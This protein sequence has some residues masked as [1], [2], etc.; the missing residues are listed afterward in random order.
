M[1]KIIIILSSALLLN[2][3]AIAVKTYLSD[4]SEGYSVDC[5][6]KFRTWDACYRQ[7]GQKC[8]TK[9]YNIID[10]IEKPMIVDNVI[11]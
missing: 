6:G 10:K 8:G 3:C 2:G 1:Y 4:G 9:G 7:V 11:T 5:S